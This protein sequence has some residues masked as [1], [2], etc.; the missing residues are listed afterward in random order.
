MQPTFAQLV[1]NN[2]FCWNIK[3]ILIIFLKR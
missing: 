2:E 1:D 3:P